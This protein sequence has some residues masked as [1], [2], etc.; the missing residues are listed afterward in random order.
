MTVSHEYLL[1]IS[2]KYVKGII[3]VSINGKIA[4]RNF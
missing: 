3:S 4:K 1:E 2:D